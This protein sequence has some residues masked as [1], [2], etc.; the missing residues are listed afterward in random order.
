M[1]I[2]KPTQSEWLKEVEKH[3]KGG[4]HKIGYVIIERP[5]AIVHRKTQVDESIC[6]ELGYEIAESYNNCGTIC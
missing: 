4:I 3:I 6:K 2:I 5:V 1:K